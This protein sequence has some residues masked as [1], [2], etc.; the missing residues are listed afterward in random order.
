MVDLDAV[1]ET[2]NGI[3]KIFGKAPVSD[4]TLRHHE[5]RP[6]EAEWYGNARVTGEHGHRFWK[7][8]GGYVTFMSR[9]R[10]LMGSSNVSESA[11][12]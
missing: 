2:L 3:A 11:K 1:T 12:L 5:C 8:T 7:M 9:R 4:V 10:K 6:E